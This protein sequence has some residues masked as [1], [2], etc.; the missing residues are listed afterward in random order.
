MKNSIG[1][2]A[3]LAAFA[4]PVLATPAP[5]QAASFSHV[6]VSFS[7]ETTHINFDIDGD[8]TNDFYVYGNHGFSILVGL[9]GSTMHAGD[10]SLPY[11]SVF[12]P[13]SASLTWEPT[14]FADAYSYIGFSFVSGGQTHAAWVLFDL[15]ADAPEVAGGGW[16]PFANSSIVVGQPGIAAVPEPSSLAALAG[17][18]ALGG[19]LLRRRRRSDTSAN[20]LE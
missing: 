14:L 8:G 12:S 6:P 1:S 13:G 19:A 10:D 4:A 15:D 16:Q 11:G 18:A 5:P 3:A 2:L 9:L 7:D 20:E 17:A